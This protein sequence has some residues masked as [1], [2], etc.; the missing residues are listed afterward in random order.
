MHPLAHAFKTYSLSQPIA[1]HT[2]KA[3]CEEVDCEHW[4]EGWTYDVRQL[5][6]RLIRAIRLS[7]KRFREQEHLGVTYWVFHPGQQ[8]FREH[9]VSNDREAFHLITP[10]S[11]GLNRKTATLWKPDEWL[12]N[13]AL[14]QDKIKQERGQ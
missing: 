7:G 3:T 5:D 12:E 1:T 9:R 13:F 8:C 6:E 14:H 11:R 4:R 2:R 10:N